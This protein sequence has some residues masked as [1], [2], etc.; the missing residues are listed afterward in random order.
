MQRSRPDTYQPPY[1]AYQSHFPDDRP[2]YVMAMI[3]VQSKDVASGKDMSEQLLALLTADTEARPAHVE[4]GLQT[5]AYGYINDVLIPY[6]HSRQTMSDFWKRPDVRAWLEPPLSGNVGWWRECIVAPVTSLDGNYSLG[7]IRYGIGRYVEQKVEQFHAYFGSMRDRVPDFLAG[8][9]DGEEGQVTAN[10]QLESFGKRLRIDGLPDNLCFIRAPF[11][12]DQSTP[13]EQQAFVD[14]M[15]PVFKTGADYL[16]DNPMDSNCISMRFLDEIDMGLENGAQVE[17]LGW[18]LTLKD[19]ER[20]THHHP[21]HL[22]IYKGVF[23]YMKRFNFEA[24]LNLG[25]EVTVVP[26]GGALL[27]YCNCHPHTGFLPFYEA[28][29]VAAV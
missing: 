11:G 25:H 19:L 6:W 4:R 22:A 18:F 24:K 13:E 15:L 29:E 2:E 23:D 5:D 3:G 12:W 20:W 17:V 7:N 8:T 21:T 9:A 27:E 26:R 1:P 14:D 28:G 16:R 10:R